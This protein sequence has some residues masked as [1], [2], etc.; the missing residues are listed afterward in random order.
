MRALV[1]ILSTPVD[2]LDTPAVLDRL[3][4]FIQEKRF[5]QVATANVDFVINAM[6]DAELRH[7]LRDCD[8]VT[9]DGMPLVW[10]SKKLGQPLP[11]RVTGAD[12]VPAPGRT[13][14]PQRLSPVYA[15]RAAR[16][17]AVSA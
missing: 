7:I 13:E 14:R 9:P 2:V 3:E 17:G 5:H 8:L 12:I 10:A 4:Q 15:R 16:R 1:C 6:S 11:E